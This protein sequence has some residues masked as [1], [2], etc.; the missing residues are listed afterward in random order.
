MG[1][2][3]WLA[4]VDAN[5]PA[6]RVA[7]KAGA[8]LIEMPGLSTKQVLEAI[9]G[10][11]PVDT[12][13]TPSGVTMQVVG[14]GDLVPKPVAEFQAVLAQLGEALPQAIERFAFYELASQSRVIVQTGDMRKYANILLRK[15]VISVD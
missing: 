5:F 4:V 8:D 13:E 2:G 9:L 7:E 11:F 1:H 12:F 6:H 15:G 3:D 14:D 10:V